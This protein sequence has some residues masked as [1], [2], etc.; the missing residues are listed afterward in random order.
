[1]FYMFGCVWQPSINEHDDDDVMQLLKYSIRV[2]E[3]IAYKL[4]RIVPSV[5][6]KSHHLCSLDTLS[7]KQR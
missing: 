5:G 2:H 1:M 3:S 6:K 7:Q 4:Y